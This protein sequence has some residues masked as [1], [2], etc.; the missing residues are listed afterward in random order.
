[1]NR[2][3]FVASL[4]LL[5]PACV[6][7]SRYD[8]PMPLSETPADQQGT[9]TSQTTDWLLRDQAKA[10]D[11]HIDF[12]YE[13]GEAGIVEGGALKVHL[14]HVL[15]TDQVMYTPFSLSGPSM[16]FFKINL[17][18]QVTATS[19]NPDVKL[20]VR[21][22]RPF[23]ALKKQFRYIKYK[24]SKEG[25]ASK[26]NL[27]RQA[28]NENAIVI[29]VVKG[30]LQP[31]DTVSVRIGDEDGLP[32]PT[33]E[34]RYQIIV[35]VDADA[36]GTFGLLPELP[37]FDTY[38]ARVHAV[39]LVAPTTL[40]VGQ[41]SSMT[42]R[43]EDDYYLPNL[44]RFETG[45][46]AFEPVEGLSFEPTL[47]LDGS[48]ESWD[49][50]VT[51]LDLTADSPG[52]YRIEGVAT[53]DGIEFPIRSNPIVV[54]EAGAD[55]IYFGDTH[56]HSILSYDADRPPAYVYWRMRNQERYDF[57]FLSDHDMIGGVPFAPKTGIL[58]RDE[59][60]WAYTRQLADENYVPGE[61]VTLYAYEWTSYFYGHRNIYW[62]PD[63]SDPPL[64]HHNHES[65][66]EDKPDEHHPAELVAKLEGRDYIA[67]PHSTAW[68]TGDVNYHWGPGEGRY[69]DPESWPEE[70]LIEFY[71]SHGTSE[72]HDNEYA[73]DQGR[74]EAPTESNFVKNLLSYNIQQAPED[75][76]NF[77]QDALAAGWRFGFIGSSD[78]HY[79]SHI[80][81]A[82]KHGSAAVIAPQ[83]TRE[84]IWDG[85]QN[86]RS[87]AVT[88]VRIALDLDVDGWPMGSILTRPG[89]SEMKW[90]ATIDGTA[91]IEFVQL[92]KW[93]GSAYIVADEHR[94]AEG[95]EHVDWQFTDPA[96]EPGQFA[97]LKVRQVDG[98][99]AWSSPV[100]VEEGPRVEPQAPPSP[101][102]A[103]E[104]PT[105]DV[106]GT[107]AP[108]P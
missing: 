58:G 69:G 12:S 30:S 57:A 15:P 23:R 88:G 83:L 68:P 49:A 84:A 55:Q 28:D 41:T 97:Y 63:E 67:I 40:P 19:S 82:Y 25:Q 46:I 87:Y 77:V 4:L 31:G 79:L 76:G 66:Y 45:S 10:E 29:E 102:E 44:A 54:T 9:A 59:S 21:E 92:V 33:R 89:P 32:G 22:P 52:T 26:D 78:M 2:L 107:D 61:F 11:L 5:S 53:I 90:A 106:E 56:L 108:E 50:C 100:W 6:F 65:T 27:L 48:L 80:D 3:S 51:A 24:R 71:S 105:D 73:V 1:M 7:M 35:R 16:Y 34:A 60:E 85:M 95:T 62:A 93:D 70:K 14:G 101:E 39:D 36:D 81:Q 47:T 13:A 18:D 104:A 103:E 72:H 43:V 64:V 17:L 98:N 42:L 38:S 91:P 86:R 99:Y 94:P 74:P 75:S 8:T 37:S 96:V 20:K